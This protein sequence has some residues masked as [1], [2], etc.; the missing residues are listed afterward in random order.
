MGTRSDII[1]HLENGK[2]ARSYCPWDGYLSYNGKILFDHYTSQSQA[3]ALVALGNLW[4]GPN[5]KAYRVMWPF[6]KPREEFLALETATIGDTIH[7]IWSDEDWSEFTYVW[8]DGKWW[9]GD[10]REGTQALVDLGDALSG[11]VTCRP[12]FKR[13]GW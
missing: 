10:A 3:E 11:K 9:M 7:L 1:V 5:G 8:E 2:W 13:R 4:L 12:R 6:A